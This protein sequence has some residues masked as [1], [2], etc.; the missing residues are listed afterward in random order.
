MSIDTWVNT[1]T[2]ADAG[3]VVGCAD[4]LDELVEAFHICRTAFM[5]SK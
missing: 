5:Y 4:S 2:R 3:N 1:P